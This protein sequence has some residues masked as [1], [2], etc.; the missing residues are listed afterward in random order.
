MKKEE[1]GQATRAAI[2]LAL[3]DSAKKDVK[4]L[5][6]PFILFL[7]GFQG[8]GK[9]MVAKLVKKE[10]NA[11]VISADGIRHAIFAR[12]IGFSPEFP[13]AVD[14][15]KLKIIASSVAARF[16]III[17]ENA[18]QERLASGLQMVR[19]TSGRPLSLIH[20]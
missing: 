13:Q 4:P 10:I 2:A 18:T 1:I 7:S 19:Q 3:F 16:N 5:E 11:I 17:D 14:A 9:T 6:Q 20:I 15:I 12:G 8:S